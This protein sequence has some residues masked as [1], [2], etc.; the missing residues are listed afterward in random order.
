MLAKLRLVGSSLTYSGTICS[1]TNTAYV[2]PKSPLLS[3]WPIQTKD[4]LS[5]PS[6]ILIFYEFFTMSNQFVRQ[7]FPF[8]F[9]L[10]ILASLGSGYLE[11]KQIL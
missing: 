6:M 9:I 5:L 10:Y 3:F 11:E 4:E 2:G 8:I 1:K 7:N